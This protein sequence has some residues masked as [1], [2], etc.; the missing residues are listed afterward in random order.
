MEAPTPLWREEP[1]GAWRGRMLP[2]SGGEAAEPRPP[3]QPP[4]PPPPPHTPPPPPPPHTHRPRWGDGPAAHRCCPRRRSSWSCRPP[5]ARA[6]EGWPWR[7]TSD[8]SAGGKRGQQGRPLNGRNGINRHPSAPPPPR[9]FEFGAR[10][11]AYGWPPGPR[12]RGKARRGPPPP[13]AGR[14]GGG[15]RRCGARQSCGRRWHRWAGSHPCHELL[16]SRPKG[17]A[18]PPQR[19]ASGT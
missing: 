7:R 15:A 14:A 6:W 16:G 13:A 12:R 1:P 18:S 19:N 17:E 3:L 10:G 5:A 4:P 9:P 8:G 2:A 11:T